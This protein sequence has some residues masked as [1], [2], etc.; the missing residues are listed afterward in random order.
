MCH[1]HSP[2]STWCLHTHNHHTL[3]VQN[4]RGWNQPQ[5]PRHRRQDRPHHRHSRHHSR[6]SRQWHRP[7]ADVATGSTCLLLCSWSH[8]W[9]GHGSPGQTSNRWPVQPWPQSSSHCQ[10]ASKSSDAVQQ[11][12]HSVWEEC[13]QRLHR[14][15]WCC[16]SLSHVSLRESQSWKTT[17]FVRYA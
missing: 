3:V 14:V 8:D 13:M 11:W 9:C 1:P 12:A 17:W 5:S 7:V 4:L 16:V 15:A 10:S 6:R 2:H